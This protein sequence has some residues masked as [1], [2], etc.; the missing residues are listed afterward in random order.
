[1][2]IRS[3]LAPDAA[4]ALVAVTP[5]GGIVF[6]SRQSDGGTT[7]TTTD[8]GFSAPYWVRLVRSG[9]VFTAYRSEDGVNWVQVGDPVAIDMAAD[10][11]VGLAVAAHEN[12]VL[13]T[14]TFDNVTVQQGA[15]APALLRATTVAPTL[16]DAAA[17]LT[18]PP[19]SGGAGNV[20]VA[21][22]PAGTTPGRPAAVD[23]GNSPVALV[24]P[25]SDVASG[26]LDGASL[27]AWQ[28]ALD[29]VFAWQ[30]PWQEVPT[31]G[32]IAC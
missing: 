4:N 5:G 2:M 6:Q 8:A 27:Q 17:L 19:A 10:A 18:A 32:I 23:G 22:A 29:Q 31:G 12:T 3:S 15:S 7:V 21:A 14:S 20:P 9:N 25:I 24:L 1:V 28:G 16:A 30:E 13:N 26:P 11:L